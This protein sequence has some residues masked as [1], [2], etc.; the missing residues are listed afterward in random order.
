MSQGLV[1]LG[2]NRQRFLDEFLEILRIA[3]VSTEPARR[4]DV[5]TGAQWTAQRL[6][7]ASLEHVEV[8]ET[9]G[10][11]VVCGDW[12]HAPG[13]PTVIFYGHFDVLSPDP[14]DL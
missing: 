7:R 5:Q 3:S 1:Y 14:V 8:F 4:Q 9:A 11:P 2:E 13:K 10:H 12:L 6:R